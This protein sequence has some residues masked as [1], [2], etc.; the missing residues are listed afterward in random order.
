MYLA[1]LAARGVW[2]FLPDRCAAALYASPGRFAKLVSGW[3]WALACARSWVKLRRAGKSSNS[4]PV[5]EFC[6]VPLQSSSE[7]PSLR[8]VA[9]PD[10]SQR[11]ICAVCY[12]SLE[13]SRIMRKGSP[14]SVWGDCFLRQG[15]HSEDPAWKHSSLSC[16]G[17]T[18]WRTSERHRRWDEMLHEPPISDEDSHALFNLTSAWLSHCPGPGLSDLPG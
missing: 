9:S 5:C 8:K 17:E 18:E 13:L 1:V 14:H 10:R 12:C 11:L 2:T 3:F 16:P 6:T 4:F 7:S 15:R